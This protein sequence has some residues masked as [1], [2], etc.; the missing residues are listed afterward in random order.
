M[1]AIPVFIG[2]DPR[3]SAAFYTCQQSILEHTD[4]QVA[5]YP[6]RGERRDGSN[7][8]IYARFLVPYLTGYRGHAIFL[9][10]DMIVRGDIGDLWDLRESRYIGV[11]VVKH[12]YQTRF[13][14][15]YLG[16]P[17]PD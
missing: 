3:E 1:D 2:Y 15:K 5:F 16:N 13:P 11:S 12:D 17:N 9:D 8:F 6:V 10:G 14:V 7:D 4:R